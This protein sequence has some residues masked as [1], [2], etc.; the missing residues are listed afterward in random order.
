MLAG[1]EALITNGDCEK[2]ARIHQLESEVGMLRE[3]LRINGARMHRV[4]PHRR[5]QYTTVSW[6]RTFV[7][8]KLGMQAGRGVIQR[9]LEE[10]PVNR[11]DLSLSAS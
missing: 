1:R 11:R 9:L 10:S 5:P 2:M 4:T 7:V 8:N 3:E 6:S